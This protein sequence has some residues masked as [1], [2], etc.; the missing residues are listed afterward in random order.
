M[1]VTVNPAIDMST[2]IDHVVQ[3]KKLRCGR[4]SYEPGGGGINVSRAIAEMGGESTAVY[5]AGGRTGEMFG[6]LLAG[7]GVKCLPL[8]IDGMTRISFMAFETATGGQYRFGM[9]GPEMS[10]KDADAFLSAVGD[11][12]PR[13]D[14]VVASGSLPPGMPGDFY[15]RLAVRCRNL[16]MRLVLD[17]SG[18]PLEE[19][20]REGVYMIKPNVRELADLTGAKIGCDAHQEE[21]AAKL[22]GKGR[23]EVV[24]VSMGS[25]GALYATEEG[26]VRINAPCVEIRSRVGAGDSMVAGIVLGLAMGNPLDEAV[27]YGVAAGSAAVMTPGSELCRSEDVLRLYEEMLARAE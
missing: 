10:E 1:T 18:A 21:A 8:E 17:T 11:I 3:G 9:P 2:E 20:A 13:P 22:A 7:E 26:A 19:A 25:A 15:A 4:P 24:V 12:D 23:N 6:E 27:R 16:G 14:L 5:A